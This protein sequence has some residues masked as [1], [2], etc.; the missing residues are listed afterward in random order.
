MVASLRG[1]V[2]TGTKKDES[3]IGRVWAAGFHHVTAHSR[4]E[5]V[6]KLMNS[7]FSYFFNFFFGP[8]YTAGN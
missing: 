4:L 3:S 6:L 2:G 5:R 7:M 1:S 8:Q